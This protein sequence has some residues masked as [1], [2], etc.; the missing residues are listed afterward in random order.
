MNELSLISSDMLIMLFIF[1]VKHSK[2]GCELPGIV[3]NELMWVIRVNGFKYTLCVY[4]NHLFSFFVSVLFSRVCST[5][6]LPLCQCAG[7]ETGFQFDDRCFQ[8]GYDT[9]IPNYLLPEAWQWVS[10]SCECVFSVCLPCCP[11]VPLWHLTLFAIEG[12]FL[13]FFLFVKKH[14][15]IHV[16]SLTCV[17]YYI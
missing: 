6:A 1:M 13:F 7:S 4:Y 10:V 17:L 9:H 11:V 15:L 5:N 3:R 12:I 14:F 2:G 8:H 16:I